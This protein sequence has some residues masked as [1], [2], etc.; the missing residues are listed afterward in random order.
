MKLNL[1]ILDSSEFSASVAKPDSQWAAEVAAGGA[2]PEGLGLG[3]FVY[4]IPF[5]F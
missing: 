3:P 2:G 4:A 1:H 5:C